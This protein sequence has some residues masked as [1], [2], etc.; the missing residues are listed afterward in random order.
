MQLQQLFKIY[1][2][3]SAYVR[4]MVSRLPP[5]WLAWALGKSRLRSRA[6]QK[7]RSLVQLYV[8]YTFYGC[9]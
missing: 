2:C 9:R 6:E 1:P 4:H 5:R 7:L 8:P 3:P